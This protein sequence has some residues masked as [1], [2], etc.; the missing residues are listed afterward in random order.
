MTS[1]TAAFCDVI[2]FDGRA[3]NPGEYRRVFRF[4]GGHVVAAFGAVA[5]VG[6]LVTIVTL[7]AA[8]LLNTT[9]SANS[10]IQAKASMGPAALALVK[11]DPSL[12]GAAD[13]SFA[14]KWAGMPASLQARAMPRQLDMQDFNANPQIARTTQLMQLAKLTPA[15]APVR[16]SPLPLPPKAAPEWANRVPLPRLHPSQNAIAR[17]PAGQIASKA[18][19]LVAAVAPPAASIVT[20][21]T[22]QQVHNKAPTLSESDRHTA[23]YDIAGKTVYMPNGDR[24]EAHSGLGDKRDDPRYIKVR[25]RGPTPPNVYDLSLREKLFHGVRAIR[26]NPVNES[27]MHGRDGMLA[28]SYMLG[29]NG[30]SNGCVSFKD[31]RKFLQAFLDGKVDRLVVVPELGNTPW[32][33]AVAQHSQVRRY[34]ANN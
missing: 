12:A 31:Y 3:V 26:L 19:P 21:V 32:R 23:L 34:A 18:A 10:R 25:M 4:I 28:H 27:K 30:Q 15:V 29:P 1:T 11:S 9:L 20:H 5:A 16:T 33:I 13:T 7:A 22:P 8:W 14:A 17:A 24:L 2:L 6:L